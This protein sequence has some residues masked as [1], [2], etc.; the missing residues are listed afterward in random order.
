M[1]TF[2]AEQTQNRTHG[3]SLVRI[4]VFSR[5]ETG[6]NQPSTSESPSALTLTGTVSPS[7]TSPASSILAS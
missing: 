7:C 6:G 5:E 4:C 2:C 1:T 3:A